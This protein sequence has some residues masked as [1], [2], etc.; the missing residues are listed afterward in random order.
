ML[1]RAKNIIPKE[2][3]KLVYSALVECHLRYACLI[4]LNNISES[5][6]SKIFNLQ[7]RALRMV[8]NSKFNE[9]IEPICSKLNILKLEDILKVTTGKML[10]KLQMGTTPLAMQEIFVFK[11]VRGAV[12]ECNVG[13]FVRK[14]STT[15]R[16]ITMVWDECGKVITDCSVNNLNKKLSK[17][18][19]DKYYKKCD[20][21]VCYVCARGKN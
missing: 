17:Y 15:L 8:A 13:I 16:K 14:N 21:S 12:N 5:L 10:K 9:H 11:N 18:F 20:R 4:W 7:K 19:N 3:R 2:A 1:A 6:K